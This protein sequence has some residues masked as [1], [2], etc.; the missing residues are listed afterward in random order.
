[1]GDRE[2]AGNA[3]VATTGVVSTAC[4]KGD[5]VNRGRPRRDESRGLNVIDPD[6]GPLWGSERVIRPMKPG[7]ALRRDKPAG[8]RR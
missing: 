3:P 7:N 1:M 6:G 5:L 4:Q 2:E 8:S